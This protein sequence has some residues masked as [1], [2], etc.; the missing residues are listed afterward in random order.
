MGRPWISMVATSIPYGD[1]LLGWIAARE[2]GV[3]VALLLAASGVWL[4]V[5]VAADVLEGGTRAIDEQLMLM[6][7]TAGDP[8]DPLGPSW[9]EEL[10][11]DVTGLGS[12]GIVTLIT[13]AA[14][15]FLMLQRK[16]HLAFYLMGAVA[17]GTLVG[18]LLKWAFARPR[19]DLVPHG[20]VVYTSS[21]PS[22]HSMISAV[23]FLTL[24]ALLAS[25]QA[26]FAMR[27]YL[28]SLA[29]L[30][31]LIVGVSRVYL[32]VHWPTDVLAGW[33]AGAAWALLC[34]ALARRLRRRGAVE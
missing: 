9:V 18:S 3:L 8:G 11:R 31:T 29:V 15:G 4:F 1:R 23:A 14:A 19:P 16:R 26:N 10:A 22:G 12:A 20:Q 33:T 21:F 25:G 5:E 24:G 2:A 7:R 13:I 28:M 27:G 34:W 32:G 17:S 30:L 6:L